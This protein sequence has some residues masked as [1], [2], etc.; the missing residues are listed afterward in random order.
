MAACASPA[1]RPEAIASL[2]SS[3]SLE[4][5]PP[6]GLL[7]ATAP[8]IHPGWNRTPASLH[9]LC[10]VWRETPVSASAR[11]SVQPVSRTILTVSCLFL[12]L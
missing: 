8:P 12:L 2:C 11:R 3:P 9:H 4:G 5:A 6:P 10:T 1:A 7:S